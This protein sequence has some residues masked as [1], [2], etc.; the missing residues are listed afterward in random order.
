MLGRVFLHHFFL[1]FLSSSRVRL[2]YE[3]SWEELR[4]LLVSCQ[5]QWCLAIL[6][7]GMYICS[8]RDQE[9][10]NLY[11]KRKMKRCDIPMAFCTHIFTRLNE[12]PECS[13]LEV[14]PRGCNE[15]CIAIVPTG[16]LE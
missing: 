3:I 5:V 12:H 4:N 11:V 2:V 8:M 1:S 10:L 14:F 6:F 7:N 16:F 9:S 13:K 15:V